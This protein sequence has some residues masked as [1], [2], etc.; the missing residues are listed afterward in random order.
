MPLIQTTTNSRLQIEEL[1]FSPESKSAQEKKLNVVRLATQTVLLNE[2]SRDNIGDSAIYE[3]IRQMV[4]GQK[5]ETLG[6]NAKPRTRAVYISVGGD[7][8]NNPHSWRPSRRFLQ[9]TFQLARYPARS[10][11]VF[12]QSIPQSCRGLPLRMLASSFA[13]LS[14]VTVR[15]EESLVRLEK[16]GV[17]AHLSFDTAFALSPTLS[18][19]QQALT[20]FDSIGILPER[21]VVIALRC[22]NGMYGYSTQMVVEKFGALCQKL[23]HRGHSPVILIQ[24]SVDESDSDEVVAKA[25][26][27]AVPEVKCI[28]PLTVEA[29]VPKW[30]L[31]AGVMAFAGAVVALR[32]HGA[33]FRMLS[34]RTPFVISYSNKGQDLIDRLGQPGCS[35]SDFDPDRSIPAIES[36]KLQVFDPTPIRRQVTRDFQQAYRD[37]S[38]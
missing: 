25:I 24:S 31:I 3:A 1:G 38:N 28:N 5:L 17:D 32:Y 19:Q 37:A 18:G 14:S 9:N 34:G 15:D 33:I 2:Y 21:S 27:R 26:M 22:F 10:T 6:A 7:I 11:I 8:F 4:P 12:G 30:D 36:T 23:V 35:L 29:S 13:R 20:L 16:L